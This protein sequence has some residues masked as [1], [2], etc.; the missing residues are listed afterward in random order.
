MYITLK[1]TQNIPL[2][3][4][5]K[6]RVTLARSHELRFEPRPTT[7]LHGNDMKI[8]TSFNQQLRKIKQYTNSLTVKGT[9]FC[10]ELLKT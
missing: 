9:L 3:L 2:V 1:D 6:K 7:Q 4:I 10:L 8:K 5:N